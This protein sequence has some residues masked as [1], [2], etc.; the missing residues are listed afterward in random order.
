MRQTPHF[1]DF[2]GLEVN[3]NSTAT[4]IPLV[5]SFIMVGVFDTNTPD[6]NSQGDQANGRIIIGRSGAYQVAMSQHGTSALANKNYEVFAYEVAASGS[7]I[8]GATATDPVVVTAVAHGFSDGDEVLIQD[9]AGMV[10]L[11]DRIF[12]VA[13]KAADTFELTDDGGASP[14][15]DIDG[16]G[17][18]AYTS[19]G[20]AYL[21]TRTIVHT[22][23]RYQATDVGSTSDSNIVNLTAGNYLMMFVKGVTD[24]TNITYDHVSFMMTFLG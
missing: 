9:V 2:A 14:A 7:V 13:D 11:N 17:F 23:R 12:K 8:T 22:H 10:E 1:V 5:N 16:S 3:D 21:A 18:T 6:R 4:A 19:G 20:V 24:A 15:N